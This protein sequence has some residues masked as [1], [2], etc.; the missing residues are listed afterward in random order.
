MASSL[1]TRPTP[2]G[3]SLCPSHSG[4]PNFR[5]E[6]LQFEVV[7]FLRCYNAIL[8]RPCYAN[9]MAI[10]N[11]TYVKLKIPGPCRVITDTTSF[12]AAYAFERGS[13]EL[14]P[15]LVES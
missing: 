15:T 7:D 14:F 8:G 10:P 2:L 9:F 3:R 6:Q 13:S 1:T 5:T 11:Y 12:M 4:T